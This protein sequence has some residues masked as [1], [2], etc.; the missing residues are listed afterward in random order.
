AG[1]GLALRQPL[2]AHV[3]LPHDAPFLRILRD[4]EGALQDAVGA[5]D[6][7]VVQVTHDPRV[8]LLFIGPHRAAV[9]AAG[10]GAVVAGGGDRLLPA[11]RLPP[12]VDHARVP[13][14]FVVVQ[15]VERVA[16]G[17]AGLAA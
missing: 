7:L 6:A 2:V 16:G 15:A 3:A 10:I 14:G 8:R 17:N 1:R 5:A 12:A 4:V 9:H 11:G 13:P